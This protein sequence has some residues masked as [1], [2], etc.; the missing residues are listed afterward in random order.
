M[1]T[2][3]KCKS[4]V[5][6]LSMLLLL[7]FGTNCSDDNT[8]E[9]DV[10]PP[11]EDAQIAM[12]NI[13]EDTDNADV[14]LLCTDGSYVM[15]CMN[16]GNGYGLLHCGFNVGGDETIEYTVMVD[17]DGLPVA[18][19]NDE[20]TIQVANLTDTDFDCAVIY[21]GSDEIHFRQGRKAGSLVL[22]EASYPQYYIE[23]DD[24]NL[25]RVGDNGA[26]V[27]F[28]LYLSGIGE[29]GYLDTKQFMVPGPVADASGISDYE[30][31]Y[32]AY[33]D[34]L[35]LYSNDMDVDDAVKFV[36][37]STGWEDGGEDYLIVGGI[38]MLRSDETVP[39][40]FE[41]VFRNGATGYSSMPET[42]VTMEVQKTFSNQ[43]YL[44]EVYNYQIAPGELQSSRVEVPMSMPSNAQWEIRRYYPDDCE[45]MSLAEIWE[46]AS[47]THTGL[48]RPE[49]EITTAKNCLFFDSP[50][51][52]RQDE[53]FPNGSYVFRE[54]IFLTIIGALAGLV[55]GIGLHS[56]IMSLAEMESVMFG[57]NIDWISFVISFLITMLFSFVVNLF[58]Y[59]KLKKVQMVESLKSVE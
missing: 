46:N 38:S 51:Q 14:L 49:R 3:L 1:N 48:I 37:I 32:L 13:T 41:I 29:R 23:G 52:T 7:L 44:G 20:V 54:T 19:G 27:Y 57:R 12:V 25:L 22:E 10:E 56:L 17:Q 45:G 39:D 43:G 4:I 28:N 36:H 16:N 47:D 40:R 21:R 55:L 8:V 2:K 35:E 33:L 42:V 11:V 50:S 30:E 26:K 6:A 18:I 9:P 58:M 53:F 5:A 31:L 59:R 34:C 24:R 15:T